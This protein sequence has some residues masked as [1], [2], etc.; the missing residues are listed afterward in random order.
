MLLS[1]GPL[2]IMRG[3]AN[4]GVKLKWVMYEKREPMH[5]KSPPPLIMERQTLPSSSSLG[6][7]LLFGG[8]K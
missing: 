2:I 6:C 8:V 5:I 4:V 7:V 1:K 3:G